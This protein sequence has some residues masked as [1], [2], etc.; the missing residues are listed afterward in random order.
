MLQFDAAI[1]QKVAELEKKRLTPGAREFH[2]LTLRAALL[3]QSLDSLAELQE[4]LR[5]TRDLRAALNYDS[6]S[7]HEKL[8][9]QQ[10]QIKNDI[11]LC[12]ASLAMNKARLDKMLH[13]ILGTNDSNTEEKS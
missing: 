9:R 2:S 12:R 4:R 11:K 13:E 10:E 1:I 3:S 7:E 8:M 6:H 5:A